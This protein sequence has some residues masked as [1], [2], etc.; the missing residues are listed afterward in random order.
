MD[1]SAGESRIDLR[2]D[3]Y[4]F[5]RPEVERALAC[6]L[7]VAGGFDTR[8][9]PRVR[10][11]EVLV[12]DLLGK[13]AA[14]F[15]PTCSLANQIAIQLF[16]RQGEGF[17]AEASSHV[18]VAEGGAPAAMAGATALPIGNG[19]ALPDVAALQSVLDDPPINVPPRLL[20]L[21][22]THTRLGGRVHE[23]A[24]CVTLA[25]KARSAG[26]AV[27]LD[28]ARLLDACVALR[29]APRDFAVAADTV[30]LSLNKGLGAP[31][32]AVLAGSTAHLR[33]AVAIQL[34]S[35]G[36]W[37]GVGMLAGA[38]VAALQAGYEHLAHA[39]AAARRFAAGLEGC[40][41]VAVLPCE[42]RTNIVLADL[43]AS[44]A[45]S[46]AWIGALSDKGVLAL[47]RGPRRLRFVFSA[48][49]SEALAATAA[50]VLRAVAMNLARAR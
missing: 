33:D 48:S 49:V 14:I 47:A 26:L 38:A 45:P 17:V 6:A 27:H 31:V 39:H 4:A 34:R 18:V 5:L 13:E 12:A 8:T 20:V 29:C 19:V 30:S 3:Y 43:E 10:E 22:N 1:R 40:D 41:T 11:L 44:A 36:N 2:S 23:V 7:H 21:E 15:V 37:R 42:P 28:G 35:G 16:C 24:D 46:S 32:G 50:A 9:D 25:E